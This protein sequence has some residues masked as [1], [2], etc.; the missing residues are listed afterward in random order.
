MRSARVVGD[1]TR[2]GVVAWMAQVEDP[3]R[4]TVT[5]AHDHTYPGSKASPVPRLLRTHAFHPGTSSVSCERPRF[6]LGGTFRS[7]G[8]DHVQVSRFLSLHA[9]PSVFPLPFAMLSLLKRNQASFHHSLFL[10][11][12]VQVIE[13]WFCC[14][15]GC[16]G[17]FLDPWKR[18][19]APFLRSRP[20][21]TPDAK[22]K[23]WVLR[24]DSSAGR[25]ASAF[26]RGCR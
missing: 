19:E 16:S 26:P 15:R 23:W 21:R 24:R 10:S 4:S 13:R 17:P 5:R 18:S 8:K 25:G 11:N 22:R 6:H 3:S 2:R 14:P 7:Y 1:P 20:S 12:H 9:F